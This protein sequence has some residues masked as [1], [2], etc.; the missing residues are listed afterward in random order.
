M[1]GALPPT[2]ISAKQ[3][4]K[5]FA[6]IARFNKALGSAKASGLEPTTIRGPDALKRIANAQ[7]ADREALTVDEED[8]LGL[9]AG[10]EV[11]VWPL[12]SGFNHREHGLLVGLN[13]DEVVLNTKTELRGEEIRLHFPR[14]NFRIRAVGTGARSTL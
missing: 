6:Y 13:Q 1:K 10:E 8:P 12:D 11:E 5:V 2:L 7:Y 9:K 3:Y 4:P 14:T